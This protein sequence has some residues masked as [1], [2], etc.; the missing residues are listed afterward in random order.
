MSFGQAFSPKYDPVIAG[1]NYQPGDNSWSNTQ[2][3]AQQL[4]GIMNAGQQTISNNL[5]GFSGW[6][7]DNWQPF[8]VD[9]IIN[10]PFVGV[11]PLTNEVAANQGNGNYVSYLVG[12][13]GYNDHYIRWGSIQGLGF[14][15]SFAVKGIVR[16]DYFNNSYYAT[17]S[18][19]ANTAADLMGDVEF[20]G[21]VDILDGDKIIGTYNL[22]AT[23]NSIQNSYWTEVGRTGYI[24]LPSTACNDVF[25]QFNIGYNY[26]EGYGIVP[27]RKGSYG[28]QIGFNSKNRIFPNLVLPINR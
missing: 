26:S 1:A 21:S 24:L 16:I 15:A 23:N 27:F 6:D 22:N 13:D 14:N 18:A 28:W 8:G 2:N 19:L 11:S 17:A 4:P 10:H 3:N 5:A 12:T 20:V 7:G 9:D 25:I